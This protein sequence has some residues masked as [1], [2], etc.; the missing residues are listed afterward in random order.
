MKLKKLFVMTL[1]TLIL[2]AALGVTATAEIDPHSW[3]L[4]A[5]TVQ[6]K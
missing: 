4:K 2:S 5:N 1:V 6:Q 3:Y